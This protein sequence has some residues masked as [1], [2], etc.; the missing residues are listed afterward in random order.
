MG[1]SFRERLYLTPLQISV[2]KMAKVLSLIEQNDL[3]I[4]FAE[5]TAHHRAGG[6][7]EAIVEGLL[8][9]REHSIPFSRHEAAA[10]D[11]AKSSTG[12]SSP[13]VLMARAEPRTYTLDTF[14]PIAI[15][16][17]K[18]PDPPALEM[19]RPQHEQQLLSLCADAGVRD[20]SLEYR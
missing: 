12:K 13:E 11:L 15:L 5:L 8:L 3:G 19:A 2:A 6:D 17:N 16:I 9:A 1:I 14:S 20:V 10:I 7:I 4:T 18:A